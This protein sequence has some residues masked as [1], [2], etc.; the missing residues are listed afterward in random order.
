MPTCFVIQPFDRGKFD[1]R[2]DDTFE[3]AIR[4]AGLEPDRVDRDPGVSIPILEIEQRIGAAAACFVELTEDNPNV[5]FE[6][7]YALARRKECCLVCS[8]ERGGHYPFD[9]QHRT[10]IKYEVQS[11]SD[12]DALRP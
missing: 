5:W 7:G 6:F 1:K 4:A 9:V 10:I 12:F 8:T 3:P 11:P 2:Y